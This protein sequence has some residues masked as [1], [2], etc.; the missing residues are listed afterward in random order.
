MSKSSVFFTFAPC[1]SLPPTNR[2]MRLSR[3]GNCD[4]R[5]AE[6]SCSARVTQAPGSAV[7]IGKG[8][9]DDLIFILIH[10]VADP[11]CFQYAHVDAVVFQNRNQLTHVCQMLDGSV[12]EPRERP[13]L[14]SIKR[15]LRS[16]EA[17]RAFEVFVEPPTN[18]IMLFF[19]VFVQLSHITQVSDRLK[20]SESTLGILVRFGNYKSQIHKNSPHARANAPCQVAVLFAERNSC[21]GCR[22]SC[23]NADSTS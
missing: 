5:T 14:L 7:G 16:G 6:M 19:L 13:I 4:C 20:H 18:D 9:G 3:C 1:S 15:S 23:P 11:L 2:W 8:L 10:N 22:H 12:L 21:G 17:T